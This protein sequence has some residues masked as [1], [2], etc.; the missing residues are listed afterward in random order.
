MSKTW[1]CWSVL[2]DDYDTLLLDDEGEQ[3]MMTTGRLVV[4]ENKVESDAE[5]DVMRRLLDRLS[6]CLRLKSCPSFSKL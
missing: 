5:G 2:L 6:S 1:Q 4:A 3:M